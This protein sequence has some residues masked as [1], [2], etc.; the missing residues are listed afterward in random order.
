MAREVLSLSGEEKIEMTIC[1]H[2]A[3]EQMILDN[4]GLWNTQAYKDI[5]TG[6]QAVQARLAVQDD[7]LPRLMLMRGSLVRADD[8]LAEAKAPLCTEDEFPD[9]MW[10]KTKEGRSVREVPIKVNDDS[11]DAMRY[12]VAYI[13]NIGAVPLETR[14]IGGSKYSDD[15]DDPW[16]SR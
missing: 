11:M 15:D 3:Q 6:V 4:E 13:D 7:G 16:W 14:V 5:T 12:G 9:Y 1:D 10:P 2:D 8:K